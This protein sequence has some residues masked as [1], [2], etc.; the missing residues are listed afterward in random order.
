MAGWS[1]AGPSGPDMAW[2][3]HQHDVWGIIVDALDVQ[4]RRAAGQIVMPVR[5]GLVGFVEAALKHWRAR[6]GHLGSPRRPQ[7][8]HR[9][10][11]DVLGGRRARR[12]LAEERGD[13]ECAKRWRTGAEKIKAEVLEK[14]TDTGFDGDEGTFTICSFWLVTAL[15]MIGKTARA[16]ALCQKLLSFAGPLL[17]CAEE[18]DTATALILDD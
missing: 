18:I 15:A 7:A 5:E 12:R 14:G 6:L 13:N 16:H 4:F 8:L 1:T 2:N 9:V 3:Q 10:Q 11:G 17:L